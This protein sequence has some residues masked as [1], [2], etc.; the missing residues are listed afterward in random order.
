MIPRSAR[1]LLPLLGIAA[2]AGCP[3]QGSAPAPTPAPGEP[4]VR[5][6]TVLREFA[7]LTPTT[8]A[9]VADAPT[10][11]ELARHHDVGRWTPVVDDWGERPVLAFLDTDRPFSS[12]SA[13]AAWFLDEPHDDQA[14]RHPS[15]VG[16]V[17]ERTVIAVLLRDFLGAPEAASPPALLTT[18]AS[19]LPP[20]W[21]VCAPSAKP[22][23][24]VAWDP[25]RS[26][27][28][29]LAATDPEDV[30]SPWTLDHV[31]FVAR[32][33]DVEQWWAYKGYE[34]C[35]PVGEVNPKGAWTDAPPPE[36]P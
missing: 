8:Y 17:A 15:P 18:L 2:L 31:E 13:A 33:Q 6:A 10:V 24:V 34:A 19:V 20:P 28:L 23:L 4:I 21:N 32:D 36:A 14:R 11:G 26:V 22:G 27:K 7:E 30:A 12:Q 29:G 9:L 5:Q 3:K 25:A 1:R 35:V 16:A